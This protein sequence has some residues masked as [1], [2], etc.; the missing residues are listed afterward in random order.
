MISQRGIEPNLDKIVDVEAMQSP[1]TQKEAQ[2]LTGTIAALTWFIS[3][4]GF[5]LQ[6]YLAVSESALSSV[7]IRKEEKV[8]RPV[9]Y[10]SRVARKLKPYFEAHPVEV[11]T[12]QPLRQIMENPSRSGR[13]VKWAIE[14]SEFDLRY[15]PRTSMKAQALADFMVECTHG[16]DAGAPEFEASKQRVWLLYVEGVSNPV[17]L[18]AGILLWS[19]EGHKIEYALR[20]AFNAMNNEAYYEALAN[21]LSLANALE[22]EHIHIQMDS[23]LLVG[24]E[25]GDFKIDEAKK[26][27]VGYLRRVRNLARLFRSCHMEYVP[28]ER[29][30]EADRLSQ[31]AMAEY[32]IVLDSTPI[33]WVAKE[34]FRTKKVMDN[35]PE[36]E[37][38]VPGPWYQDI[39]DFLKTGV[40]PGD[41]TVVNKIQRQSLRIMSGGV[42]HVKGT[43]AF[44]ISPH[45]IVS[46]L[47]PV[48]F[49][50]WGV[51]IVGDLPRT[52]GAKSYAIVVVDYFTK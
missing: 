45:E 52:P 3:R 41:P 15:K 47:C 17:G 46:M 25:K 21:G 1:Q 43:P 38:R 36:G 39:M 26:R 37:G 31:L 7:L 18:G 19:P 30:Q 23:Q 14:L 33:E 4:S 12:D 5:A 22:A 32:G 6:L 8:Q 29:N 9:Y 51:D 49:Y 20:F 16:P 48:P 42:M 24:H 2:R 11:I 50:Q 27:L 28:R 40:L 34:A 35:A 13:I 44:L 10:V